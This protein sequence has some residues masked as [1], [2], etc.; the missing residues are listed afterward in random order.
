M[1]AECRVFTN[2][3]GGGPQLEDKLVKD[4][5][6]RCGFLVLDL[7]VGTDIDRLDAASSFLMG[8]SSYVASFCVTV[9]HLR[10]VRG[11][12]QV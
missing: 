5:R 2:N 6:V 10:H 4:G 11:E 7:G 8:S 12:S 1:T 3:V 9:F